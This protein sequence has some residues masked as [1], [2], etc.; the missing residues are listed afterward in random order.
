MPFK[1]RTE[2]T[3]ADLRE[4][5]TIVDRSGNL[6]LAV[7]V[8]RAMSDSTSFWLADAVTKVKMHHLTR[9]AH[10]LVTVSRTADHAGRVA[11]L[12]AE[13]DEAQANTGQRCRGC[14]GGASAH[15]CETDPVEVVEEVLGGEVIAEESAAHAD[16]REAAEA[17]GEAMGLPPFEEFT[18]PEMRSHLYLVH[19]TYAHDVKTKKALVALHVE[20]HTIGQHTPHN[21][22]AKEFPA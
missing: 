1:E 12:E 10:D 3:Y 14:L 19:G 18:D 6:W 7:E 9:P 20:S 16:A 8:D 5:D 15:T 13:V 17:T 4:G 11:A 2:I 21:H 22:N